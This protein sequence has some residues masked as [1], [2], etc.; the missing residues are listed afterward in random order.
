MLNPFMAESRD[1]ASAL[2][3][4][5][6]ALGTFLLARSF[7]QFMQTPYLQRRVR[8]FISDFG[9]ALAIGIMT[10]FALSMP[11]VSVQQAAIPA[12]FG[13]TTGRPW[14]VDMFAL[15]G[16][17]ILACAGPALLVAVLLFLDQN[18]TTRLVN[19]PL[20]ALH[21][22][23]GYHLDLAVVSILTL[24]LSVFGL[25][26]IVAATV[27]SLNH[28]KSLATTRSADPVTGS[29]ERIVS[30]K[31]NRVSGLAIHL[32][33]GASILL[34][35]LIQ[36]IPMEVLFGLFLFMGFS[37]LNGTDFFARVRLWLTD[38][39]Q[40]PQTHYVRRVPRHVIHAF[41]M[42]QLGGLVVLWIL[43]GSPAGILFPLLIALLVPFRVW[44]DRW[45]Q[46]GHLALLD[47]EEEK[48][49]TIDNPSM[50]DF[51]P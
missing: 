45:F 4:L 37:T 8:E 48:D 15:P 9:P 7:K 42:I 36:A 16:W 39:K 20:H 41:T 3:T 49:E 5:V 27:H 21:K 25:P 51:R 47:A 38:S 23:A 31:E 10:M 19:S 12:E 2:M 18:I 50:G 46:P 29:G 35:P 43:K 13:T 26:W 40:Y 30:V 24:V 34:L 17:M 11:D 6:L 22:G 32:L 33:L 14:L 44:L 28:V 1:H